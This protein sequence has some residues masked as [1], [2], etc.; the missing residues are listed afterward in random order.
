MSIKKGDKRIINGWTFYDWANS[1]YPLVITTAIFP[2]FFES[3]T[4]SKVDYWPLFGD[5]NWTLFD[6]VQ[7]FGS[8]VVNTSLYSFVISLGFLVVALLSPMLS[9]IADYSGS[10][11]RFL[12]FFCYLGSISCAMLYFWDADAI[13]LS[14]VPVLLAGVGFWG[15]LVFYNAYLPEIAEPKDH[16]FISAKGFSRGYIGAS[17]LLICCLIMIMFH[18]TFGLEAGFAV[19]LSFILTALWWAGFAQITYRVL[20]NNLYNRKPSGNRLTKGFKELRKVWKQFSRTKRLKRFIVAFFIYSMGV[21]T[22]MYMATLFGTKEVENM[23]ETGLIISVLL[24]QFV[25][26]PGAYFFS[27]FS[28]KTSNLKSLS[29]ALFI[30]VGICIYSYFIYFDWQFYIAAGLV[31]WVMGGIQ[32][33]SRSTYSKFLPETEDHASYFSFYDVTEKVGIVVGTLAYGWIEQVT[34]SMRSSVLALVVFFIVGYV[35]LLLVPKKEVLLT[36]AS[37]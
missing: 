24:I 23:P 33:L 36:E 28:K 35:V 13:E 8:Y 10:K 3:N 9:G 6:K 15:S 32:S 2:I 1:A 27:W 12:Q 20:P 16:D 4:S 37:E 26:V 22:V 7:V 19:K 34:G 18:D 21:Q 11:K 31:G 25:A 14:M 29:V 17:I 30:W 5:V